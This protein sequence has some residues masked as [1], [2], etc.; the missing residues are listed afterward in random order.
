MLLQ[1]EISFAQHDLPADVGVAGSGERR[2]TVRDRIR[3]AFREAGRGYPVRNAR[4]FPMVREIVKPEEEGE[5]EEVGE[6]GVVRWWVKDD[7]NLLPMP[8]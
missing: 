5:E 6:E 2:A 1:P 4:T 7:D 8:R 3:D